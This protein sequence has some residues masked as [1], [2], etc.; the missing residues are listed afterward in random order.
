MLLRPYESADAEQ[1]LALNQ[2]ALDGVGPLDLDRLHWLAG[3]TDL[4]LVADDGGIAGFAFVLCPRTGYDS[5]N[6]RWFGE[7][8]ETFGYLDR[9]VVAPDRRRRGVGGLLYDAAED[10]SRSTG[11]LVCEVYVDPPNEASLAFHSARGYAEVGRLRQ[12][13]G[14]L[15]AMLVKELE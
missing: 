13:D 3:L 14:K 1:I 11:R 10:A 6:Y 2:A 9:V 12:A 7:R 8:Y 4:A 5:V 15:S